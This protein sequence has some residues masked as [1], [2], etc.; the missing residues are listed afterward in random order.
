MAG[1]AKPRLRAVLI[2]L[3]VCAMPLLAAARPQ[4]APPKH[5]ND[6]PLRFDPPAAGPL[7]R[8]STDYGACVDNPSPDGAAIDCQAL[9]R[10]STAPR[11]K[12][13]R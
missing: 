3:C 11:P 6:A 8:A 1:L 7:Q 5:R 4:A 13:T 2:V 10:T 12:R 9:V